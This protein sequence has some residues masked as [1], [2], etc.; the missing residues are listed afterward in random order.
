MTKKIGRPRL[1]ASR[2]SK[3]GVWKRNSRDIGTKPGTVLHHVHGDKKLG[4]KVVRISRSRH[5]A[6]HNR[7]RKRHYLSH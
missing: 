3:W 7:A 1:P 6:I 5:A 2:L 4:T